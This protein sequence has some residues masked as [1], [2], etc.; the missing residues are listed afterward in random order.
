MVA[1]FD[2]PVTLQPGMFLVAWFH[3]P[4]TLSSAWYVSGG[5]IWQSCYFVS[6]LGCFWWHGLTVPL[7]CLQHGMFLVGLFDSPVTLSPAWDVSGGVIWQSCY[8]IS[9]LGLFL[10]AVLHRPDI[11]EHKYSALLCLPRCSCVFIQS[12]SHVSTYVVH[13]YLSSHPSN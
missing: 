12:Y 3:S 1:C 10:T 6:I 5:V 8:F 9:N 11:A 13:T 4:V 2:S 7:L